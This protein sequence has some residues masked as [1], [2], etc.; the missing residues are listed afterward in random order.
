VGVGNKGVLFRLKYQSV[1]FSPDIVKKLND[2]NFRKD[3]LF[4]ERYTVNNT[5]IQWDDHP[6]ASLSSFANNKSKYLQANFAPDLVY[7]YRAMTLKELL[8]MVGLSVLSYKQIGFFAKPDYNAYILKFGEKAYLQI[9]LPH[10]QLPRTLEAQQNELVYLAEYLD[11]DF[12]MERINKGL[13]KYDLT[14]PN[15]KTQIK[16]F[17]MLD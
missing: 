8:N 13:V 1:L 5:C 2:E 11:I 15:A 14:V 4:V 17:Y 16:E 12:E 3:I 9:Y 6:Y 10:N 7:K